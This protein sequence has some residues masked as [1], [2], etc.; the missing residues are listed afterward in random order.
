LGSWLANQVLLSF[1]PS[2]SCALWAVGGSCERSPLAL[3]KPVVI[4]PG[5]PT[6]FMFYFVLICL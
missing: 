6:P 2:R 4:V 5:V 3:G 1:P